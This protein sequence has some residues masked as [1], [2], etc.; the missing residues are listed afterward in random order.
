MRT[1]L[2]DV[3]RLRATALAFLLLALAAPAADA[4]VVGGNPWPGSTI[5]YWVA[6]KRYSAGVATAARNWNR[7]KVGIRFARASRSSAD[8]V[9]GY[10]GPRCG[11][12][13]VMGYGG[14]DE[15]TTVYLGAGCSGSLISLTATH[16]FGHVLGLDH[17][18][19]KCARMNASF[20]PNGTPSHCGSHSL[21]YWL[22]HPLRP[23]DVKGAKAIYRSS[24]RTPN[25]DSSPDHPYYDDHN[26]RRD[27]WDRF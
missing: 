14:Y 8:V 9:V 17:E 3:R 26:P 6:A 25:T 18:N 27:P 1:V 23:D 2:L 22:A 24:G 11:G 10:G 7:S 13:T 21:A 4:Y 19:S 12:E 15:S 20:E 16:E 5:T